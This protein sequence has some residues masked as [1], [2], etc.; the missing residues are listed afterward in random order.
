M[1]SEPFVV[2]RAGPGGEKDGPCYTGV[3]AP[4]KLN[5]PPPPIEM[6]LVSSQVQYFT[7]QRL[8]AQS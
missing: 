5:I 4:S 3:Q 6:P 8:T 7:K 2:R 1:D